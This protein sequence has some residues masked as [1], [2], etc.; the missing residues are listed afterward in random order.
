MSS[1]P[2]LETCTVHKRKCFYSILKKTQD[3]DN[4]HHLGLETLNAYMNAV[5]QMFH[6]YIIYKTMVQ[7]M[8][9]AIE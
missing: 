1:C 8:C 4:P 7:A 3:K 6:S 5:Y 2:V 9:Q